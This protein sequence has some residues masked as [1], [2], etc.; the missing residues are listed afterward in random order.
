[1]S[2]HIIQT[3]AYNFGEK[4]VHPTNVSLVELFI[5]QATY[6]PNYPAIITLERTLNYDELAHYAQSL[7]IYL[8]QQGVQHEVPVAILLAPGI[9]QIICQIAILEAGGSCVPLD[10]AMPDERLSF[11]LQDL[12][13]NLTITDIQSQGRTLP[14]RF[15]I[16]DQHLL[17]TADDSFLPANNQGLTQRTHILFTSGTTGRP[18]AVQIE[19]R[20]IIRLVINTHYVNLSTTDRVA[21]IA[22]PTFDASLFEIWGALLNGAAVVIIPKKIII[23]PYLFEKFLHQFHISIMFITTALFNLVA[24]T[25]PR[26]FSD[27]CYLLVGGEVLTPQ[28]LR[29]VLQSAPPQHL[30]NVYGP[31][32]STTFTLF[33]EVMLAEL[34]GNNVPIGQPIDNTD[35]FILDDQLQLAAPDKIGHIYIGGEGLARGYWNRPEANSQCFIMADLDGDNQLRRI[36]DSGDLGWQRVDGIFMYAGRTDNQIKIRG[37]R[38]EIEEIEARLLESLFLQ[39][40]AVCV[41]RKENIEPYLVSF[42]VPEHPDTFSKSEVTDW[43]KQRLPDYML[44]RLIV[45]SCLPLTLNGKIDR[46]RLI[47]ELADQQTLFQP[48]IEISENE[49][50]VLNIWQQVLDIPDISLDDD[51]FQLGG[52]SLQSAQLVI[53]VGR[54]FGKRLSIQNLYDAP[55]PRQ[56]VQS[57]Q[58]THQEQYDLSAVLCNDSLL[59]SDIQPLSQPLQPWLTPTTGRVLLTGATGFLGAFFLRDLL[60]QREIRQVVCLVRAQDNDDALQRIK[61]NL[62][63]YAFWQDSFLPRLQAV[64]SDIAEPLLALDI[65][66]YERLTIECDVIFHLAAHVNYIQPYS[67]HYSGNILGTLNILRFAVSGK[68]KPLHYVSTIAVFG[69]AGLLSP[70]PIIY[71]DDDIMPYLEGMQYDSGYSQSK[72]AV[73]RIIWQAKERGIP[74]AVYRPGFIMGD[75]VT[76]AGNPKDFVARLIRGCIKIGAYPKL[77][78]QRKEFVP[79]NY[80]SAAL[81]NISRDN[82]RLGKAYHL[83][84]P[85]N[86]QS[87]DLNPFFEL[88]NQCGYQLKCL[89]YPEWIAKLETDKELGSNP[90]MPLLPMLSEVVYKQLTRWEVYE[91][92]PV[93]DTQNTKSALAGIDK[94]LYTPMNINLLERYLTYWRCKGFL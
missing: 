91:N 17:T 26:A 25:C 86:K 68:V 65:L 94:I 56:L 6:H 80:V 22:N 46:P 63:Q 53:E 14:S 51:F 52:S 13:V 31:T 92:M 24:N 48:N 55:T 79:V 34:T 8:R 62:S 50:A 90:L 23:D 89:N 75:S 81:F 21:C 82:L 42:I 87:T 59:P 32:E 84:P 88:L 30:L 20:G 66:T 11:M 64:A 19:A 77:I 61:K 70:T 67:A 33:Y 44:P 1:M 83:V 74:L 36:Y 60:L 16:F 58:Q 85:D 41:I 3:S 18:K 49:L 93:Y 71:E 45:V 43:L 9:A 39:S 29:L 12:Q 2:G 72:W 78:N 28:S 4:S 37:H 15:I 76:G 5:Q 38:I 10:P 57:I 40:A 27:M 47:A 69:P 73:E 7:A 35:A 54:K